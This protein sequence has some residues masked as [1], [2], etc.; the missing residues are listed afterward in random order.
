M[1]DFFLEERLIVGE[2][3]HPLNGGIA[4]TQ[5]VFI[6]NENWAIP[7]R[8]FLQGISAKAIPCVD[9][10]KTI[11]ACIKLKDLRVIAV[12]YNEKEVGVRVEFIRAL[13]DVLGSKV[14]IHMLCET[15]RKDAMRELFIDIADEVST[16]FPFSPSQ[17]AKEIKE[18]WFMNGYAIVPA[19]K[20]NTEIITPIQEACTPKRQEVTP[21]AT[22]R[23]SLQATDTRISVPPATVHK[24]GI[25]SLDAILG[26]IRRNPSF[27]RELVVLSGVGLHGE[28]LYLDP[29]RI[30]PLPTNPR[31]KDSPFFSRESIAELGRSIRDLGQL[32]VASVCPI[33]GDPDYDFQLIDGER[34]QLACLSEGLMLEVLV[35]EDISEND[36]CK[37]Y[38]LS[39]V[40][41]IGKAPQTTLEYVHIVTTLRG[42]PYNFTVKETS[43]VLGFS[44][45][46][47]M[48]KEKLGKLHPDVLALLGDPLE[49]HD[50][51]RAKFER[52]EG[53]KITSHM[54]LLLAD[55]PHEQQ[56]AAV[57]HII[58]KRQ[59]PTQARVYILDQRRLLLS[60][61]KG[62]ARRSSTPGR[63]VQSLRGTC[64]RVLDQTMQ[65]HNMPD[66]QFSALFDNRD[67]AGVARVLCAL[68]DSLTRLAQKMNP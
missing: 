25:P 1:I 61:G 60:E 33:V 23:Q 39:V 48:S 3:T 10:P 65:F 5:C 45:S 49:G 41:N 13:R 28:R 7:A 16:H 42:P 56:L 34:R 66:V 14:S 67:P 19:R 50:S 62:V 51:P 59:T 2:R 6:G 53:R 55:L 20:G 40:K 18:R 68:A 32:E 26:E 24:S 9:A 11:A 31:R 17:A 27:S 43:A 4:M 29:R 47:V 36:P 64:E 22:P 12:H 38:V 46:W 35:R 8:D 44:V 57:R 54:G 63:Q 58:E 15:S 21:S 37:L 52:G 30:K